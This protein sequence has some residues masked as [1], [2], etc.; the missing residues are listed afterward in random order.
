MQVLYSTDSPMNAIIILTASFLMLA[1]FSKA[2]A[3][4]LYHHFDTSVFKKLN[5]RFWNP[6]VSANY[7]KFLPFTKFRW[8][9]W[10]I[11]NTI[12]IWSFI[13][14]VAVQLPF[15]WYFKI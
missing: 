7:A 2:V 14:S 10:H 3:D 5:P 9:A 13:G 6:A 12:M 4:T 8:D 15:V 11:A 1:A